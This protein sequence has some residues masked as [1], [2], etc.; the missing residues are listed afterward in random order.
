MVVDGVKYDYD[1]LVYESTGHFP[2]D[3]KAAFDLVANPSDWK[4]P[5][6]GDVKEDLKDVVREAV[7]FYTATVPEFGPS[8]FSG[9]VHVKAA[10][11]RA[12]PAG[13]H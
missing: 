9:Y 3:L 1:R 5:I 12:G 6:S 2:A 4:A 7:I 13:D 10:G 11:Y 8:S